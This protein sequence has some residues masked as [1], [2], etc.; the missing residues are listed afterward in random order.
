MSTA[1]MKREAI[2]SPSACSLPWGNPHRLLSLRDMQKFHAVIVLT[3]LNRSA[4]SSST[5]RHPTLCQ[6]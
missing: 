6:R 3:D 5:S 1:I 4:G 2:Q